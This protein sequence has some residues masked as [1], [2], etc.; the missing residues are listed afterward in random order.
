[1]VQIYFYFIFLQLTTWIIF[2]ILDIYKNFYF[3]L[4]GAR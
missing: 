3:I 4:E 1:M 2:N